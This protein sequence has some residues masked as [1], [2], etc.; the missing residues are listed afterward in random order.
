[1]AVDGAV[2]WCKARRARFFM[3]SAAWVWIASA[4]A[5]SAATAAIDRVVDPRAIEVQG[6]FRPTG[7]VGPSPTTSSTLVEFETTTTTTT[8]GSSSSCGDPTH[9][10]AV[11][12]SD[13]LFTLNVAVG[14]Q[15]CD[16]CICDIDGVGGVS[17][18]DALLGLRISIGQPFGLNCPICR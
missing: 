1:M 6:L 5:A 3:I 7:G 14:L 9:D 11:T 12:A 17:A 15:V 8:M 10:G 4:G 16:P 13:A 2:V 18:T